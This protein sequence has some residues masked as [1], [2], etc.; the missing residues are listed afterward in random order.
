MPARLPTTLTTRLTAP[1]TTPMTIESRDRLLRFL[2]VTIV[3]VVLWVWANNA[4]TATREIVSTV[5]TS[6]PAELRE[7]RELRSPSEAFVISAIVAGPVAALDEAQRRLDEVRLIVGQDGLPDGASEN[8]FPIER[9][10]QRTLDAAGIDAR[11]RSIQGLVPPLEVVAL[12][13]VP[14]QLVP[15]VSADGVRLEGQPVVEPTTIDALMPADLLERAGQFSV[16]AVISAAQVAGK[17]GGRRYTEPTSELRIVGEPGVEV[18]PSVRLL[19]PKANVSFTIAA[20]AV[21]ATVASDSSSA[22]GIPV[23][24]ALPPKDLDRYTVTID[25]KDSFLRNVVV[26]ATPEMVEQISKGGAKIIA[27][28]QLSSDDLDRAILSDGRLEK[29]VTLWQLPPGVTL[30][31]PGKTDFQLEREREGAADPRKGV[32]IRVA[33]RAGAKPS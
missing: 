19:Q 29:P 26:N 20:R 24:V 32:L 7:S 27:F 1:M 6:L 5:S 25:A 2:V 10:L 18:P 23:Q 4:T 30:V 17:E 11:V 14:L 31:D 21:N 33:P 15:L 28:V 22:P 12:A 13:R 3:T 8:D 9:A 16:Q